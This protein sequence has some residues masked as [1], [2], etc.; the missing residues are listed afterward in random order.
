MKALRRNDQL[1]KGILEEVFAD[2]LRFIFPEAEKLFDMRRKFEFLD[3]ELNQLFVEPDKGS[4]LRLVDKLVKVFRKDGA[5]EWVLVHV[6]VQGQRDPLFPQRMFEYYYRI[7]DKYRKPITAIAIFTGTQR[8]TIVNRLEHYCFGT[9][10]IYEYNTVAIKDYSDEEL[11][12][13]DNPFALV[14]LAAKKALLAG[15]V[16]EVVLLQEKLALA[17]LLFAK[18]MFTKRKI[19]NI[20]VFLNNYLVFANP[21][22]NRIFDEKLDQITGRERTM[23]IIEQI[24]EIRETEALEK[25]VRALLVSTDF[26]VERIASLMG[27]PEAF[28]KTVKKKLRKK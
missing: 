25:G 20:L 11:A 4:K 18:G 14:V 5:E 12:A 16:P 13:S 6:E 23:G 27:V 21:K 17:K 3:K 1:W 26:P 8:G 10:L 24:A 7:F 2:M 19:A 15:R 28:V 9:R 22:T